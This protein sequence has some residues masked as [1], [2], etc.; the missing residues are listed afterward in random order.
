MKVFDFDGTIYDGDSSI[1]FYLFCLRKKWRVLLY[2]PLQMWGFFGYII[3]FYSKTQ[4]KERFFS[5]LRAFDDID[6]VLNDFWVTHVERLKPVILSLLDSKTVIISASPEFLL[7]PAVKSMSI[8]T[9]IATRMDKS[10]GRITGNNCA[11]EDKVSRFREQ[12]EEGATITEFYSDSMKDKYM[13][14]MATN[15]FFVNGHTITPWPR[16]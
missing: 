3:K 5:F 2:L 13:A 15:A 4:L 8:G 6:D 12:V 1:D 9:L 16:G 7:Y 11:G 10:C 14:G